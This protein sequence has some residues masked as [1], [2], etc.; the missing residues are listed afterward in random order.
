MPHQQVAFPAHNFSTGFTHEGTYSYSKFTDHYN[1]TINS[2][3]NL[4]QLWR[5]VTVCEH[6]PT[7]TTDKTVGAQIPQ[8][9]Q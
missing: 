3:C 8:T 7:D 5:S 2:I 1:N 4:M 9:S 6:F